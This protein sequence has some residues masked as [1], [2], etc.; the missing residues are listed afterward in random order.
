MKQYIRIKR[1]L[2][3]FL[4]IFIYLFLAVPGLRCR[5]GFSPVV[6]SGS[7]PLLVLRR[8]VTA[9]ASPVAENG[10]QSAVF[11]SCGTWDQQ[12][13]L[14]ALERRL[15]SCG[16]WAQLFPSMWYL[17]G[18]RIKPVSPALAGRFFTTEPR[19]KPLKAH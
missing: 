14:Q 13:Q 17:L 3:F 15:N 12:L 18:S 8:L 10:L 9:A 19:E 4:R 2:F 1:L 7:D 6:A 11:S 16:A 5:M